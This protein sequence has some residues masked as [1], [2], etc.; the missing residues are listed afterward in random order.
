MS[1]DIKCSERSGVAASK[2]YQILW[3]IR[4]NI[5]YQEQEII[6]SLYKTIVTHHLEYCIQAWKPY[7][8]KDIDTIERTQRRATNMIPDLRVMKNA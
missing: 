2:G 8:K 1:A 7:R 4:R 6:I 3:L 5:T